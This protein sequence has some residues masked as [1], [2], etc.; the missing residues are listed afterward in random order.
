MDCEDR[1]MQKNVASQKWRVFAFDKSTQNPVTGDAANITAVISIDG[2]ATSATSDTN[3]TELSGGFYEFNLSQAETNG[4]DLL[5]IAASS[6]GGV[7]VVGCPANVVTTPVTWADDVIQTGDS[8]ARI[9]AAGASLTNIGDT[10]LA[11]L[12]ATISSRLAPTT[13]GRTLD[14][15]TTGEAGIDWSNVG[16]PATVLN[17]SATTISV[18]GSVTGSVGSVTGLT[19]ANLDATVSSRASQTSLDTLDDYVD[20]EVAAIKAKTDQLTFT[21]AN[22]VDA[23]A[24]TGGCIYDTGAGARTVVP[25]VT[26]SGGP[27]EN[28]TIRLVKGAEQYVGLTDENGQVTFNVDDGT[29]TV[30]ITSALGSFAGASLSVTGTTTPTYA[31]TP[32]NIDASDADKRTGYLVCYDEDGV[33][34]QGVIVTATCYYAPSTGLALDSEPRTATSGADGVASF[35]NMI[36]GAKYKISRGGGSEIKVTIPAGVTDLA[37]D[38]IVGKE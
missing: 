19:V 21:V 33:V 27:L 9:G 32:L 7:Q 18:A 1:L 24:L 38:S 5:I 13:S 8:Y 28:A 4:N 6:T 35:T 31:M 17:L 34:E 16:S 36:V 23:N 15:S 29:W 10:R 11:N 2:G 3:P 37:L 22:Q 12:D 25:T 26:L 14:V 20:T 30:S